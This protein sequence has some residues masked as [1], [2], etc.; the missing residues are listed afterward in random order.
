[1]SVQQI[2][3]TNWPDQELFL[4]HLLLLSFKISWNFFQDEENK[5]WENLE[6]HLQSGSSQNGKVFFFHCTCSCWLQHFSEEQSLEKKLFC[7]KNDI[8]ITFFCIDMTIILFTLELGHTCIHSVFLR[9]KKQ[10]TFNFL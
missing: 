1:M 10:W 8:N 3:F 9:E 2:F 4:I 6:D 5:L 7:W